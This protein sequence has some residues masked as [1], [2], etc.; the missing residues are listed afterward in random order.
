MSGVGEL[1]KGMP[2]DAKPNNFTLIK[3]I[4]IGEIPS[5]KVVSLIII[6]ETKPNACYDFF[7][8]IF[9]GI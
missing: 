7:L 1:K 4:I 3:Y 2:H 6:Y 8:R 9:E 5:L